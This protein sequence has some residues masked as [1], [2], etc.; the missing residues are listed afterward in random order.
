MTNPILQISKLK[1]MELK[2]IFQGNR[3][4]DNKASIQM[5]AV[6]LQSSQLEANGSRFSREYIYMANAKCLSRL[7]CH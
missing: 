5:Q 3:I 7:W 6:L 2:Y 1:I 4:N